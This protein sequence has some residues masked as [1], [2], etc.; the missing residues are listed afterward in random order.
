MLKPEATLDAKVAVRYRVVARRGDLDDC[1][2]LH[3]Q[4]ERTSDPAIRANRIRLSLFRFV[5]CA[6]LAHVVFTCKHQRTGWANLNAVTAIN[7]CRIS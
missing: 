3:V 1:V 6:V 4:G 2:V 5:P 7:T